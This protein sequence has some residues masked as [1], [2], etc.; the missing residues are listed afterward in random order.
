MPDRPVLLSLL[1]R[2]ARF[3]LVRRGI[4]SRTVATSAGLLHAY[5]GTGKGDLPPIVVLHGLGSAAT[6]F[7]PLMT[8]FLPHVRRVAAPDLPGH[9]FSPA[10]PDELTPEGF[11]Q[12]AREALDALVPEPMVL[13]GS[14]MG[15]AIALR[16]AC[17]RPARLRALTL[18]SPAGARVERAEWDE[19]MGGFKIESSADARRLMARIYHRTPWYVAAFAPGFRDVMKRPAIR[20]LVNAASVDDLPTPEGLQRLPMPLL[21]LW[22]ESERLLPPSSLEYFRRHLP[23]HAVIE[24]PVGF[25]HCPHFEEPERLATRVLDFVRGLA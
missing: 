10:P 22:G 4:Q 7:G 16:Y 15:G 3:A 13:V 6:G 5:D 11:Y 2:A 1:E 25:G 20:R 14:S 17:E 23:G 8:R 19:L 12:A 24:R 21:L 9:G 18:V